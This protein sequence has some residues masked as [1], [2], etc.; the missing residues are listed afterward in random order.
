MSP[1]EA[2][3]QTKRGGR[4]PRLASFGESRFAAE[5]RR[6]TSKA[7][8]GESVS[9]NPN[10]SWRLADQV[11]TTTLSVSTTKGPPRVPATLERKKVRP[12]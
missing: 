7:S 9:W 8:S 12:L 4:R 5:R 2:L 1:N 10:S 3:H 11:P 6:Y